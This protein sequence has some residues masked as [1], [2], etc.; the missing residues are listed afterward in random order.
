[1]NLPEVLFIDA[2]NL[3]QALAHN[4]TDLWMPRG[5]HP[6]DHG[7]QKK[8]ASMAFLFWQLIRALVC[9]WCQV[10]L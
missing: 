9:A 6:P 5:R 3:G 7:K 4:S 8:L 2:P 10:N 1:M